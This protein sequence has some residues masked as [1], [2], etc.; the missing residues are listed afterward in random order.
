MQSNTLNSLRFTWNMQYQNADYEAMQ[1]AKELTIAFEYS[2][3]IAG[4][5]SEQIAR[6]AEALQELLKFD[7]VRIVRT[8]PKTLHCTVKTNPATFFLHLKQY[9]NYMLRTREQAIIIAWEEPDNPQDTM[10]GT[11]YSQ[12]RYSAEWGCFDPDLFELLEPDTYQKVYAFNFRKPSMKP[13]N[14]VKPCNPSTHTPNQSNN[15]SIRCMSLRDATEL[16]EQGKLNE[17]ALEELA[18][19]YYMRGCFWQGISVGLMCLGII[20]FIM[21][22]SK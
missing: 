22:V 7:C 21:G 18:I 19:R 15:S 12:A 2:F 4:A 6:F 11:I 14:P 5:N 10:R 1:N 17:H 8:G 3:G 13:Q 20:F 9:Q 16:F